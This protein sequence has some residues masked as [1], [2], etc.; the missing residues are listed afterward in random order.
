MK[1]TLLLLHGALGSE[2]QFQSIKPI[3]A[4]DFELHHFNFEGHGGR[5]RGESFS[6]AH[7]ASN[8]HAY[9]QAHQLAPV[10]IFGYSMGGYVALQLALRHPELVRHIITLGTKF[11]WTP[12][13]ATKEVKMLN[14]TKIK[15]KV[16]TYAK[17]LAEEHA[18]LDWETIMHDTAEMMINMGNGEKLS[19]MELGQIQTPVTLGLGSEDKM[20]SEEETQHANQIL[21][22]SLFLR[23]EGVPHPIQKADPSQIA[24]LIKSAF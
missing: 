4:E 21:P 16:P 15:E 8:T 20:V 9:I 23:L 12:E 6:I 24:D 1:P 11:D 22:H 3:L 17:L 10:H 18:P 14:P 19:E 7:F 13:S 2:K 5:P